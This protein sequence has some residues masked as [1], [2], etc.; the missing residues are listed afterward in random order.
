MIVTCT[1]K[2]SPF[3]FRISDKRGEPVTFN[4]LRKSF[5]VYYFVT[6]AFAPSSEVP[7]PQTEN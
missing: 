3:R 2:R 7:T 5:F 1:D 6:V 4:P